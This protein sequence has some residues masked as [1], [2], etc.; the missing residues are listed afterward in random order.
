MNRSHL[1]NL[2]KKYGLK[3]TIRDIEL[4]IVSHALDSCD[5]N[6]AQAARLL[7]IKRTTLIEKLKSWGFEVGRQ[8]YVQVLQKR[9]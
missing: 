8:S 1:F 3:E 2:A 6:K 9:I 7:K 4:D 5:G